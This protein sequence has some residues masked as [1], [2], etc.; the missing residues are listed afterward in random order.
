MLRRG[1]SPWASFPRRTE[2]EVVATSPSPFNPH[3]SEFAM[4]GRKRVVIDPDAVRS[5]AAL[6]L[7]KEQVASALGIAKSTWFEAEKRQPEIVLAFDQG[8]AQ[9]VATVANRLYQEAMKGNVPSMIFFLKHVGGWRDNSRLEISGPEE[10]PVEI[11]DA[12]AVLLAR[13]E[14]QAP[15]PEPHSEG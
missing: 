5:H 6:G 11:L 8:K 13:L 7:S 2:G 4:A 14:K 10:G 1:A 3:P 15:Q 12:R 9:S